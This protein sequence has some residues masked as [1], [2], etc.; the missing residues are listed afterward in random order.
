MKNLTIHTID[1]AMKNN[2]FWLNQNSEAA[3]IVEEAAKLGYIRRI[4]HTQV[5][6]KE[7]GIET[8]RRLGV[9][10]AARAEVIERSISGW[11][12]V[13]VAVNEDGH[14]G[15][16][17][18]NLTKPYMPVGGREALAGAWDSLVFRKWNADGYRTK[19]P[20]RIK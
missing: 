19:R 12:S 8:A 1:A 11:S 9:K 6:W 18:D 14:Y 5:E 20:V 16:L 15:F 17:R 3:A 4:S 7:E 13:F 10:R 2:E